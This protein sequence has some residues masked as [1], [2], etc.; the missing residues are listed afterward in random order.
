MCVCWVQIRSV[1]ALTGCTGHCWPVLDQDPLGSLH[2][3]RLLHVHRAGNTEPHKH[4]WLHTATLLSDCTNNTANLIVFKVPS[5][6]QCSHHGLGQMINSITKL[7]SDSEDDSMKSNGW[8]FEMRIK[9]ITLRVHTI[10]WCGD[11]RCYCS[12]EASAIS[13]TT[14]AKMAYCIYNLRCYE[15]PISQWSFFSFIS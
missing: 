4:D 2:H 3:R 13:T 11:Y 1:S 9:I 7:N 15:H 12:L 8:Q 5:K 6:A 14:K 10:L